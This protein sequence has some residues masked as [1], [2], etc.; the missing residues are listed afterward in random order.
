MRAAAHLVERTL[1][2]LSVTKTGAV[3]SAF[4]G[5]CVAVTAPTPA[6][7]TAVELTDCADS[8][9]QQWTKVAVAPEGT[10]RALGGCL[11]VKGG[12]TTDRTPVRWW[13]CNGTGAQRWV[14]DGR[15]ALVNPQSGRCL[16][17]PG[18][19]SANGTRPQIYECNGTAAQRW[20]IPS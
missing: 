18:G 4:P 12:A 17:L 16:D 5:K 3:R 8:A 1:D 9:A 20:T 19:S 11:D 7:G 13:T 14:H 10:V 15:G 2:D 6:D